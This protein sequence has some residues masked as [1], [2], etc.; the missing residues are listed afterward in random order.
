M[1]VKQ[2]LKL[3]N[4]ILQEIK[5]QQEIVKNYNSIEEGNPRRYS[6]KEALVKIDELTYTLVSL[7]SKC[8]FLPFLERSKETFAT[9]PS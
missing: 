6:V 2:A 5:E 9:E 1:N 3:K 4:K 8:L 7:K